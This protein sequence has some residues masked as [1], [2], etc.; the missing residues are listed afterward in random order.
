MA[1]FYANPYSIDN[2]GFYFDSFEQYEERLE[3]AQEAELLAGGSG[4]FE[5]EIEYID[6]TDGETAI[7]NAL[8]KS[9]LISPIHIGEVLVLLD[10]QSFEDEDEF[11]AYVAFVADRYAT[12]NS[13][14]AL[15]YAMREAEENFRGEMTIEDAAYEFVEKGIVGEQQYEYY[16]DYESFGRDLRFDLDPDE[17]EFDA[18]LYAMNNRERGE[19]YI[20]QYG[21]VSELGKE[22]LER[23]FDYGAY[24]RDLKMGLQEVH[25]GGRTFLFWKH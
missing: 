21:G 24:A 5:H 7:V 19:E 3:L 9:G 8:T 18:E 1:T 15:Q 22:T 6:G 4:D 20:E 11:A 23:Y 2:T 17:S 25:V 14:G 13:V 10:E 12:F 16:F